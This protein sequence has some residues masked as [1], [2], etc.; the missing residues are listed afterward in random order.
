[1]YGIWTCLLAMV[2]IFALPR[3]LEKSADEVIKLH[4]DRAKA[5]EHATSEAIALSDVSESSRSH[6][7]QLR[8]DNVIFANFVAEPHPPPAQ[9]GPEVASVDG[10][11]RRVKAADRASV[12]LGPQILSLFPN[13]L[14]YCS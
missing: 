11:T 10:T 12:F 2:T 8:A 6:E 4:E 13:G 9:V 14:A 7:S 5:T 1:M 3:I